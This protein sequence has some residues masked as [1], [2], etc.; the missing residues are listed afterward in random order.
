M[1]I[2]ALRTILIIVGAFLVLGHIVAPVWK[3]FGSRH[4]FSL[5]LTTI[6]YALLAFVWGVGYLGTVWSEPAAPVL[7]VAS[8]LYYSVLPLLMGVE[9][10]WAQTFFFDGDGNHLRGR[11]GLVGITW[12]GW[13]LLMGVWPGLPPNLYRT[14]ALVGWAALWGVTLI[15]WIRAY[16]RQTWA[17]RRNRMLYWAWATIFLL[18]GQMLVLF[19]VPPVGI[20]GLLLHLSGAVIVLSGA[21]QRN[22]PN[23]RSMLRRLIYLLWMVLLVAVSLIV[24]GLVLS[25]ISSSVTFLVAGIAMLAILWVLIYPSIQRGVNRLVERLIP[26]ISYDPNE[27]LREYSLAIANIIDLDQ[28]ADVVTRTVSNVLKVERAALILVQEQSDRVTLRPLKGI[29]EFPLQTV[30]F[31]LRNPLVEHLQAEQRLL[32]QYNVEHDTAF[33]N[34]LPQIQEWL[35][36][37]GMEIYVPI[38]VQ[39][40]LVGILAVGPPCNRELFGQ[41]DQTFLRTVANQ[42]AVALQNA[43]VVENMRQLTLD[44]TQLNQDLRRANER[45]ARLDRAK[46]DFL[47]IA[48]HELR[49][50]LTHVKGYADVLAE[51]G[52]ANALTPDQI[53]SMT[54]NIGRAVDRLEAIIKAIVD[55][56]A[57]ERDEMD[58]LFAPTTLVEV[59]ELALRPWLRPIQIRHQRLE[60][61]GIEDIPPITADQYRLSQAFSNLI[62]NAIKYTPDE[63]RITIQ[64]RMIGERHY[65][66]IVSDTGVGID[67]RDQAFIF[68]KFYSGGDLDQHSSGQY[69]FKGGGPGL[70][71]SIARGIVGAHGGRIW[72][73]SPGY[74]ESRCPGSEF[75]V[76]LP[77]DA[78]IPKP[79]WPGSDSASGSV[80]P[81]PTGPFTAP[82]P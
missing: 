13:V 79:H 5:R 31:E 21:T 34:L 82:L 33:R 73:V 25:V 48:S 51:L 36:Q 22:L 28:L 63:G 30:S 39:D 24:I 64:A 53:I 68:D 78:S 4:T 32:F 40:M 60:V 19:G 14:I 52:A 61:T 3:L 38:F 17:F 44:I 56:A 69:S 8:L 66:V 7:K 71:L 72:V 62:S 6:T 2:A 35:H 16:A 12:G 75:H 27:Q 9:V 57:I 45:A 18:L 42:T 29:G 65:E 81:R 50:P 43:R 11:W 54:A 23:V 47:T 80:R 59:M 15:I 70:G 77:L 55:L 49:T 67:H 74:D 26:R 10:M 76:V 20:V 1:A 37:M 41:Q 46:S 58:L